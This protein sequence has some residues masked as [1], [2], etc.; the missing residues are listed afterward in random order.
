MTTPASRRALVVRGGWDG[1]E[2]VPTTEHFARHLE[3]V[4]F[5]V[6]RS[7]GPAVY[8]DAD[9]LAEVDLIVQCITGGEITGE[10]MA[11]LSRAVAAG[12]GLAGWHGGIT[13]SFPGTADFMQLVG[14]VFAAHPPGPPRDTEGEGEDGEPSVYV[15]HLVQ[16]TEAGRNHPVTRGLSDF[17]LVSENYW[18]LADDYVDV[19]ATTTQPAGPGTPWHRPVVSP[20]V[21]VRHWGRGRVF[22]ATPGH[23]LDTVASPEVSALI[24]RG[25][26]WASR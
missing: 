21:W 11:G 22:V 13:G 23:D 10:E 7:E 26:E 1:H 4:G 15:P 14:G 3:G 20:A 25:L 12:T 9:L 17:E 18:I 6:Q 16:F 5:T 24:G 8:A 19:L 2:P